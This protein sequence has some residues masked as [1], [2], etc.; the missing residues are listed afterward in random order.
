MELLFTWL[1]GFGAALLACTLIFAAYI[2]MAGSRLK[3]TICFDTTP[4]LRTHDM[5]T[6]RTATGAVP[7]LPPTHNV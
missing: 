2:C 3:C 5:H 6:L 4:R 1:C 7:V